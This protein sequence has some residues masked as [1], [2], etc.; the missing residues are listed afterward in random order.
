M[1]TSWVGAPGPRSVASPRSPLPAP[2]PRLKP[3]VPGPQPPR[4]G[5]TPTPPGI[6]RSQHWATQPTCCYHHEHV[7]RKGALRPPAALRRAGRGGASASAS[8]SRHARE[9]A[10]SL[11]GPPALAHFRPRRER[12]G[13]KPGPSGG[14]SWGALRCRRAE[15]SPPLAGKRPLRRRGRGAVLTGGPGVLIGCQNADPV[16]GADPAETAMRCRG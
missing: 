6:P 3:R 1:R 7:G 9:S 16:L 12:A 5:L 14:G 15:V 8:G 2:W 4:H 11:A 13:A 10:Q